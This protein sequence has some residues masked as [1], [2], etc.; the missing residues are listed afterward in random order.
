[1]RLPDAQQAL[2]AYLPSL[3]AQQPLCLVTDGPGTQLGLLMLDHDRR[4]LCGSISYVRLDR[5]QYTLLAKL[6]RRIGVRH[7]TS[8]LIAALYEHDPD[9]EPVS[10]EEVVRMRIMELRNSLRLLGDCVRIRH[11]RGIGYYVE[12]V[13]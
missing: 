9:A 2:D 6:A 12:V 1:M 5:Q 3:R 11:D 13:R 7:E 8:D 4:Q 10:A